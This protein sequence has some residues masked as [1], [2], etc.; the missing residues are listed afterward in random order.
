VDVDRSLWD[1]DEREVLRENTAQAIHEQLE[2]QDNLKGKYERRWIWELFQNAL[3]AAGSSANLKIRLQFGDSFVFSHNGIPFTRKEILHLVF[4]GSTKRESGET[5]GRYGT[6]FLTTHVVSRKLRV[7]GQLDTG[8]QFEFLLDRSGQ[9]PNELMQQMEASRVQLLRSLSEPTTQGSCWTEFEYP[10][11]DST[12]VI[13]QRALSDL[14]RIAIPVIA[15]NRKIRSVELCG[16]LEGRYE[17]FATEEL[18]P[19]C[20][21][22]KVGDPQYPDN[23]HCL[24][25]AN[26]G[27]LAIA[28]PLDFTDGHL[29]VSSPNAIPRLF[30]AFPLFGTESFPFPF[31]MNS[32]HAIPTE[33]RNGLFLGAEDREANLT[34][35]SLAEKSWRLYWSILKAATSRHWKNLD[36]LGRIGQSPTFEWLDAQW[37]ASVLRSNITQLLAH[38]AIVETSSHGLVSPSDAVFPVAI[39]EEWLAELHSLTDQLYHKSV[40][41]LDCAWDWLQNLLNWHQFGVELNL[42]E[43]SLKTLMSQIGQLGDVTALSA[44]VGTSSDPFDWLNRLLVLLIQCKENWNRVTLLP[45]QLGKFSTLLRLLRDDGIDPELKDIADLL[46]EG[47]RNQLLDTRITPEVQSLISPL[48]QEKVVGSLLVAVRSRK[49]TPAGLEYVNANARLLRWL[50]RERRA[51]DLKTYP[52]MVRAT[53]SHGIEMLVTTTAEL[54]APAEL[55]PDT[56][57]KFVELFPSDHVIS[58]AYVESLTP[59]DWRY[60][61]AEGVCRMDPVFRTTRALDPDEASAM[62]QEVQTLESAEHTLAEIE[63][64]EVAFISLKDKGILDTARNSKSKGATFLKFLFDH[65]IPLSSADLEYR[66][67]RCSCGQSHAVHSA[68]W[69]VPVK[70]KKWVHES[71]GHAAYVSAVNLSRLIRDDVSLMERLADGPIF[72]FLARLGVSPSELRRAALNLPEGEMA[73]LE[74]AVMEVLTATDNDP[75]RLEQVADLVS[76]A[77]ELLA[78]FEKRKRTK[79]RVRRNQLLGAIVEQLFHELFTSVEIKAMGLHLRRTGIGSDFALENDFISEGQENLFGVAGGSKDLLIELK[80][81]LCSTATMT[82]TQAG[83]AASRSESF[84]LCV[85]PLED[86]QPTVDLVKTYSRFVPLIGDRLHEKVDEVRAIKNLQELTAAPSDGIQV[87]VEQGEFRYRMSEPV[88]SNAL[89]FDDFKMFLTR[90]FEEPEVIST[91]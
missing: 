38:S 26:D 48:D 24:A 82:H 91:G 66:E 76:S 30:V 65:V 55:W 43:V 57:R 4:H 50:V 6:G 49:P 61:A 3:D 71:K 16:N 19:N 81:T 80:S 40:V 87:V 56:A 60:L 42:T 72:A 67:V 90:F 45:N 51:V 47:I 53:D 34:N 59:E 28:V 77:P 33:E 37:L 68:A 32:P 88:W 1:S 20:V 2:T 70:E 14:S 35:K 54:L 5:I 13:V 44:A 36:R 52:L 69:L 73:K 8:Q 29:S 7:R 9:T 85:V 12:R 83:L 64:S 75:K 18:S 22:L 86:R 79:E 25:V 63:V 31:V 39:P 10:T 78:E 62:V 17:L 41:R 89:S 58:S 23:A 27:D 11:D 15:F 74:R 46:G 21:L 84:V